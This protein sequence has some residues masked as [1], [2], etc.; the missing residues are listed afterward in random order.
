MAISG[1]YAYIATGSGLEI[2]RINDPTHPVMTSYLR[3]PPDDHSNGVAITGTLAYLSLVGLRVVDVSDPA[4]PVLIGEGVD[5][6]G[7]PRASLF[8][9]EI[10]P[11]SPMVEACRWQT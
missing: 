2:I 6:P 10:M 3:L 8:W 1:G 4:D 9:Q 7:K 11:T 5:I